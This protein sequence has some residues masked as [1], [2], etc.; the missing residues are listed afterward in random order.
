MIEMGD[1][2]LMS[3]IEPIRPP[4]PVL[5]EALPK[6]EPVEVKYYTTPNAKTYHT[7][8]CFC[9]RNAAELIEMTAEEAEDSGRKP[10]GN[11]L[12]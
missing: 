5:V 10:C 11:C 4:K 3:M 12:A 6:A 8:D 9:I 2:L 1:W 7:R